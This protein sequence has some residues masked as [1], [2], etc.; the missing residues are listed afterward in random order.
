M[1]TSQHIETAGSKEVTDVRNN[2]D[3][4]PEPAGLEMKLDLVVRIDKVEQPVYD[5]KRAVFYHPLE[6]LDRAFATLYV[7]EVIYT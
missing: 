2:S 5:C 1:L 4:T 6:L 7:H 3:A